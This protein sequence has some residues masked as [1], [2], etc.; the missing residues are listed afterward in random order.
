MEALQSIDQVARRTGLTAY[1]LRY[2]ERIGLL[3]PVARAAGGQRLY[4]PTDMAWLDFLLRLRTT[5]MSIS[6]MQTFARLRSEGDATVTERREIL[7][8]HLQDVQAEITAM[9]HAVAALEEKIAHYRG[10]EEGTDVALR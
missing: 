9:Q 5:H 8:H 3:A 7:E 4:A 2:Y 10:L 6:K 1:T